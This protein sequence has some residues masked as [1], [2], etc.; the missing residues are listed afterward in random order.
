MLTPV[1]NSSAATRAA[2]PGDLVEPGPE[3][4]EA[5]IDGRC[6]F[7]RQL[8][9]RPGISMRAGHRFGDP[10]TG[11][12]ALVGGV[13]HVAALALDHRIDQPLDVPV[14]TPISVLLRVAIDNHIGYM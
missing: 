6:L 12:P 2:A 7:A 5:A 3:P 9:H 8:P 10:E 14:V 4:I 13:V 11:R 1:S